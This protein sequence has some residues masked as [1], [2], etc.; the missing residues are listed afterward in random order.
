MLRTGYINGASSFGL[1]PYICKPKD[2]DEQMYNITELVIM[3]KVVHLQLELKETFVHECE[4]FD[5][6][7]EEIYN[8]EDNKINLFRHMVSNEDTLSDCMEV[9][10]LGDK[11]TIEL[12]TKAQNAEGFNTT[13]Q[14][15]G[16]RI[17]KGVDKTKKLTL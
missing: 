6:L 8:L 2:L 1:N 5:V 7:A 12:L 15:V 13:C 11:D 3:S 4:V 10:G 16:I 9:S 17:K 14:L